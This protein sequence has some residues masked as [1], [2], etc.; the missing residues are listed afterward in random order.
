MSPGS[1]GFYYQKD[2]RH[3]GIGVGKR[4]KEGGKSA[5]RNKDHTTDK[6]DRQSQDKKSFDIVFDLLDLAFAKTVANDKTDCY[7]YTA[8]HDIDKI[9]YSVNDR[10]GRNV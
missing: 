7:R 6:I 5:C 8:E 3:E 9:T 1:Q 10:Y 2:R 4:E